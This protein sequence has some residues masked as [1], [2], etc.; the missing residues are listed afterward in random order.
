V[1]CLLIS[2]LILPAFVLPHHDTPTK[3]VSRLI[4]Q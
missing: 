4:R 1:E 3:T 2:Q